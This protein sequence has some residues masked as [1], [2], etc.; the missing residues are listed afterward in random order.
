MR[1]QK[2]EWGKRDL[3]KKG[4]KDAERNNER[5]R[6]QGRQRGNVGPVWVPALPTQ[7]LLRASFLVLPS[8]I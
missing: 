1:A 7:G 2:E 4:E 3:E 5:G 6:E 8:P